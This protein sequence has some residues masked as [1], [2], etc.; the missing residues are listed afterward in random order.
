[1]KP[2]TL[3]PVAQQAIDEA[4]EKFLL[5][6][7]IEKSP[8]QNDRY[9]SQFFTIQ[10]PN[11]IRPILDCRKINEFIQC[12]HFKMEGV[13]ALR[14]LIEENDLITKIDLKDAYVVVPIHKE[15]RQFLSFRHHGEI[16]QYRSLPFGLSVAPRVFSKLMRFALT[17]LSEQ[18]IRI[19]YYL[20]DICVLAKTKIESQRLTELVIKHLQD[21]GFIISWEKSNI[22][23]QKIQDFLGFTFNT[24]TMTISVPPT[25]MKELTQRVRQLM[26]TTTPFSCRWIAALLGKITSMIPAIGEA[27]LHVRFLQR[28]L[29]GNLRLQQYNWESPCLV[30]QAAKQELEWWM[31]QATNRNGLPIR[32]KPVDLQVPDLTVYVDASDTGWGVASRMLKTSGFWTKKESELS[33]NTRELMTIRF[34][35]QL[36]KER[37][38]NCNILVY[39]DNKTAIKYA[40]KFRGTASALLQQLALDIQ[41]ICNEYNITLRVQHIA[42]IKNTTADRLSRQK[43]PVHEWTL[44]DDGFTAYSNNGEN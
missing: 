38:R 4:V 11:K 14:E 17:P 43:P 10:E 32:P 44:P 39:S 15:S 27:L 42:G 28:D 13:P 30:S 24:T 35:L 2:F 36:H 26:R 8:M 40:S 29:A 21:L 25:K 3:T 31:E 18:G 12:H 7:V 23:P 41:E 37:Y 9:L 5:A 33:I 19:V 22:V 20:D 16:F 6:Q 34:A 1:M